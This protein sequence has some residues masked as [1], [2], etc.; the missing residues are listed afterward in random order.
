MTLGY[1]GLS[2]GWCLKAIPNPI[3]FPVRQQWRGWTSGWEGC[4]ACVWLKNCTNFSDCFVCHVRR[5]SQGPCLSWPLRKVREHFGGWWYWLVNCILG[6]PG[7]AASP[8]IHSLATDCPLWTCHY[9][10]TAHLWN[11]EFFQSPYGTALLKATLA[12]PSPSWETSAYSP[13]PHAHVLPRLPPC[14]PPPCLHT[15]VSLS[16]AGLSPAPLPFPFSSP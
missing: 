12:T 2:S 5:Y 11:S 9:L 1:D 15:P 10:K 16:L 3:P 6:S 4:P 14:A 7:P 13:R 8:P